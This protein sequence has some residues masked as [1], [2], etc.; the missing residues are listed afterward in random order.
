MRYTNTESTD[1][2]EII[3]TLKKFKRQDVSAMVALLFLILLRVLI[4]TLW[5]CSAPIEVTQMSHRLSPES[6]GLKSVPLWV[7]YEPTTGTERTQ[8]QVSTDSFFENAASL[9]GASV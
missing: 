9:A 8:T 6:N 2:I 7:I 3:C 4:L 5:N 1:E